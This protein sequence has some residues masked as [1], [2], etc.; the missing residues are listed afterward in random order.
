MIGLLLAPGSGCKREREEVVREEL[1]DAGYELTPEAYFRAAESDDLAAMRRLLEGGVDAQVVAADGSTALHAAARAGAEDSIDF[2]LQR[3]L[4]VDVRN[5]AERTPLME[6]V[7]HAHPETVSHLLRQGADPATRDGDRYKPL[8]LAVREGRTEMVAELAPYVRGD[9]DDALLAASILGQAGMIDELTNYGASIYARLEDGRTPLMLAAGRGRDE[10]VDILLEIGAN[11][12]ATDQNGRL[13]A[14][15]AL[16]AGFGELAR[17]LSAEPQEGDFEL[18]EPVELGSEM[19]DELAADHATADHATGD[20]AAG[21]HAA[22]DARPPSGAARE[23]PA[24]G[25]SEPALAGRGGRPQVSELEGAVV[26][27]EIVE[28]SV[29]ARS[30]SDLPQA[31]APAPGGGE[32]AAPGQ[33]SGPARA[34]EL[35]GRDR[36]GPS[37]GG[38]LVMR[39]YRQTELPVEVEHAE[40]GRANVRVAGGDP[41]EVAEGGLIPGSRLRVISVRQKMRSGKEAGGAPQEVSVVEVRDEVS[42][43]DRELVVGLPAQAHDPVALVEDAADGRYYVA[44]TGQHFRTPGGDE[45]VVADVRTNQLVIQRVGTGETMT[46]PLRGSRG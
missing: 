35:A 27:S 19:A 25:G 2:L 6:A 45:W 43:L 46:I 30:G 7:L 21:D 37:A 17:R 15:M 23:V 14:D 8:M 9:L 24:G 40:E 5:Q 44:R 26:G 18:L 3:G 38:P 33:A 4:A 36:S 29:A 13:A 11:R 28:N 32:S 1:S 20:H 22:G 41:V 42:G 31:S 10:A 16:E 39:S 12:F 34:P